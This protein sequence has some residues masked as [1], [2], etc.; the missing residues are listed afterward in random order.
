VIE[1]AVPPLRERREDITP[2]AEAVLQRLS[3]ELGEI[4]PTLTDDAR[5][6]LEQYPFPG[7]VRE[8]ENVLERA[9]ALSD[10]E[11]ITAADLHLPASRPAAAPGGAR[12]TAPQPAMPAA[13]IPGNASTACP[14]RLH[15]TTRTRSHHQDARGM[16]LQQDQGRR[17][18]RHHLPRDAVQAQEA[19]D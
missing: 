5:E 7:N 15:R 11:L 6:S 9:L 1:L 10:G 17:Q 14:A 4:A 13:P 8:L 3:D 2:L 19:G 18:A 16:P 12:I